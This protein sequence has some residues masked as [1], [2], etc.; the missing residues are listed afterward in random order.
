MQER[1][2]FRVNLL[3][4]KVRLAHLFFYPD[5]N[6]QSPPFFD[7]NMI[8]YQGQTKKVILVSAK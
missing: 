6:Q 3:L 5:K 7:T 1:N 8:F 4:M 2:V